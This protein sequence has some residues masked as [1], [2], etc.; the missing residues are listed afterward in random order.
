MAQSRNR[1]ATNRPEHRRGMT[2][3]QIREERRARSNRRKQRKRTVL[4]ALGSVG[5]VFIIFALV[6]QQGF[7]SRDQQLFGERGPYNSGG[8]VPEDPDDGRAHVP[9]AIVPETRYSV[10]PAT[11]GPHWNT[12]GTQANNFLRA[13]AIWGPHERFLPDQVLIH[14]LEHGG[15][16]MHYDPTKCSPQACDEIADKFLE[17]AERWNENRSSNYEQV[18]LHTGFIISPYPDMDTVIALTAWRHH[19]RLDE[20]DEPRILEFIDAYFDRGFEPQVAGMT[21]VR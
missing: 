19:L 9:D 16:G 12:I 21:P 1:V 20:V 18:N 6:F 4:I 8:P 15:I 13:P 2:R 17:V 5:A 3:S 7:I 11:S 10:Y 14:N